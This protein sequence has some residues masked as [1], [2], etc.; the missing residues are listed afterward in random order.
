MRR[1]ATIAALTLAVAACSES[2]SNPSTELELVGQAADIVALGDRI[3]SA[4]PRE[5]AAIH[6]L[7]DN[8]KLT[9]A[10]EAAV[11]A[12]VDAFV[13]ATAADRQ[14]LMAIITQAHEAAKAGKSRAEV[15]AIL[16]TGDPIRARLNAAE[17]ALGTAILGVLT[18]EQKAWLAANP[19]PGRGP[20]AP[21]TSCPPL[22]AAQQ[23]QIASL[24]NAFQAAN[25]ADLE[26]IAAA[27][28]AASAARRN[29]ASAADI[30]KILDAV[31]AARE[32][33]AAAHTTLEAAIANVLTA[34]QKAC[35]VRIPSGPSGPGR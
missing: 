3:A 25:K 16:A 33:V 20:V 23:A 17:V 2:P 15:S 13:A 5:L 7:P 18:A 11:K 19:G 29:G 6:R 35:R 8:L 32:R 31:K 34:E 9:A 26:A 30:Q 10:Q 1:I 27:E 28:R 24:L 21:P 12:L 4:G 22:T 14:A